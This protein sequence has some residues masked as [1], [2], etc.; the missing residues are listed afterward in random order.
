MQLD[1]G[2]PDLS[3]S[4]I[5]LTPRTRPKLLL[6]SWTSIN[7]GLPPI[8]IIASQRSVSCVSSLIQLYSGTDPQDLLWADAPGPMIPKRFR[9][10]IA[11][12][13]APEDLYLH[14]GRFD[15]L[16]ARLWI[17]DDHSL[18]A[19]LSGG[20]LRSEIQRHVHR[21][22]GD[23]SV[24]DLFERLCVYDASHRRF[25][26]FLEGLAS[27]DVR[28]DVSAQ[29]CFVQLVNEPFIHPDCVAGFNEE[30]LARLSAAVTETSGHVSGFRYASCLSTRKGRSSPR[31]R[32]P[33][34]IEFSSG[35]SIPAP[36][37]CH[38]DDCSR[39]T[40]RL[41]IPKR[42]VSSTKSRRK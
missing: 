18:A 41:S 10:E 5:V 30:N 14:P 36:C 19:F 42:L 23:W 1:D 39:N 7:F 8:T 2:T 33:S 35:G 34:K 6:V 11:Q 31:H 4:L 15:E 37:L 25:A 28:P 26:L 29:H 24:D 13:L 16:L 38:S 9:R 32:L 17:I 12:A 3:G 21:N 40:G 22:P 20:G 27:A